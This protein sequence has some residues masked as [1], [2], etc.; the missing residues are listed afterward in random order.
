[1]NGDG[2]LNNLDIAAF[3]AA[4]TSGPAA[5]PAGVRGTGTVG[6]PAAEAE[7]SV[8]VTLFSDEPLTTRSTSTRAPRAATTR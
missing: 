6:T 7:G 5:A 3:V 8:A 2:T 4:L 1:M